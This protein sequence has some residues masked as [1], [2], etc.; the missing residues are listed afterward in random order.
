MLIDDLNSYFISN[1]Y[2]LEQVKNKDVK[3]Y[4]M[5]KIEQLQQK[6]IGLNTSL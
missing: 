3:F 5:K 4:W 2:D 1:Q 6:V